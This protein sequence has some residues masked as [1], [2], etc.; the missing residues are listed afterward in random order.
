MEVKVLKNESDELVFEIIGSDQSLA[1][2]IAER[3]NMDKSVT[4]AASKVAHPLISNPS[5][6]LKTKGKKASEVLISTLKGVKDE[7]IEFKGKFRDI[8]G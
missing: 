2:L 8:S 7:I 5:V 3:L 6:I 1:Q 4:F